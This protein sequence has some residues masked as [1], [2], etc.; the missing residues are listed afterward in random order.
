MYLIKAQAA[1]SCRSVILYPQVYIQLVS[2]TWLK[3]FEFDQL[4]R[5]PQ[6]A[7]QVA[8]NKLKR[9]CTHAAN[10]LADVRLNIKYWKLFTLFQ[11]TVCN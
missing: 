11:I 7:S 2:S 4:N 5:T 8:T 3:G 6:I 10:Q 9:V 1:M